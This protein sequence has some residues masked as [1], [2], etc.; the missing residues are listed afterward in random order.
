MLLDNALVQYYEEIRAALRDLLGDQERQDTGGFTPGVELP[1]LTPAVRAF[2]SASGLAHAEMPS[3]RGRR[4][5]LLDLAR[6]P[7]TMTTK[8]FASLVIVARAV[9]FIQDTGQRVTIVTPSSAN[10]AI[11]L[12]DA[13]LRALRAG[14]VDADQLNVVVVVPEGSVAKLR[15]SELFTDPGLRAR[16]PVAV[17]GGPV[18]GTVKSLALQLVDQFRDVLEKAGETN[19]WYTLQLENYLAADVVRALAEAER[20]PAAPGEARL[21]VHAVSS[22]YGLLGHAYG[23]SRLPADVRSRTTPPHYLLVQHLGAPDMVLSLYNDGSTDTAALPAYDL[24]PAS[25]MFRQESDPRY[26]AQTFDPRET[27]DPTFYTR[28][29]P[30]SPRMNELIRTQGGGGIVVSL[31]ECLSRYGQIRAM[32]GE[33]GVRLPANPTELREWS[34]T[35]AMTG[36]LNAVDRGLVSEPDILVHGSGSYSA[37]D[38]G[39]LTVRDLHPV[40]TAEDLQHVVLDAMPSS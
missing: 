18:P 22:A 35:M 24:D 40:T 17:Y 3:Y 7:A 9:R 13:V 37:S 15:T 34:L 1:D 10:K 31:A 25:G 8:T 4:L 14:L 5:A 11:A 6:N 21:H 2:L 16:N 32:L 27:L 19:L 38:Y 28:N 39:H 29:P 23:R 20:F 30:T 33:V 26:P 36:M 12:R